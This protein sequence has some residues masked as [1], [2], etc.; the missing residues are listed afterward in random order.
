MSA[1]T[2]A[3]STGKYGR[4]FWE[5]LWRMNGNSI[6]LFAIIAWVLYG[7]QPNA[8]APPDA[9]ATFYASHRTRILIAAVVSGLNVLNLMWFAAT[10]R[11]VLADAGLDGWGAA[12]I[13]SSAAV[14]AVFLLLLAANAGL[15]YSIAGFGNAALVS[16]VNDLTWAVV[17]LSSFPARDADHGGVVRALAGRA[18]LEP[19]L[20]RRSRSR[21]ARRAGRHYLGERRILG[22]GRRLFAVRLAHPRPRVDRGLQRRV[23]QEPG[24]ACGMV[25]TQHRGATDLGFTTDQERP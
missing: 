12:A 17:V 6:V 9:V 18:D 11:T 21:R 16:G 23:D 24:D 2:T 20:R 7:S 15:A 14:G 1:S 4:A 8:G 3:M 22:T 10:L 25:R 5:R 13:A 19:A